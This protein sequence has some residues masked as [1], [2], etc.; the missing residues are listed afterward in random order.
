VVNWN[1]HREGK[2]KKRRKKQQSFSPTQLVDQVVGRV[3]ADSVMM[4]K[5][6]RRG[7]RRRMRHLYLSN[8]DTKNDRAKS[9]LFGC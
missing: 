5:V 2:K 7:R 1:Q 9:G 8:K 4:R 3:D 6:R